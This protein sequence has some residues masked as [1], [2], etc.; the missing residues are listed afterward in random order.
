MARLPSLSLL[1]GAFRPSSMA[2]DHRK[3]LNSRERVPWLCGGVQRLAGKIQESL[4]WRVMPG[5][6]KMT[7]DGRRLY[8]G[9]LYIQLREGKG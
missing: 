9:E 4:S 5:C 2:S 6:Q 3:A 8:L 7:E 1:A